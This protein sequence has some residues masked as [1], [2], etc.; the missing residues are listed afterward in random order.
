MEALL[1]FTS[2]GIQRS[3]SSKIPWLMEMDA[4]RGQNALEQLFP[5]SSYMQNYSNG[6]VM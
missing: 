5:V 6:S 3:F 4:S 2:S 1:E